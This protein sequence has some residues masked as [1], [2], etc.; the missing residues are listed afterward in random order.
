MALTDRHNDQRDTVRE[1]E[2][3]AP[4]AGRDMHRP[5]G[6]VKGPLL[7]LGLIVLIVLIAVWANPF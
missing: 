5:R 6:G 4:E 7:A 3:L 2:A 1:G